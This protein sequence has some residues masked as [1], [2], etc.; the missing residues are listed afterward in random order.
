MPSDLLICSPDQV[1]RRAVAGTTNTAVGENALRLLT[2]FLILLSDKFSGDPSAE[3][4]VALADRADAEMSPIIPDQRLQGL[5]LVGSIV[6]HEQLDI[7]ISLESAFVLLSHLAA[8]LMRELGLS[9]H[10][11]TLRQRVEDLLEHRRA[12]LNS[13]LQNMARHE[14]SDLPRSAAG[15]MIFW[16]AQRNDN[17]FKK[18]RKEMRSNPAESERLFE[19]AYCS[20]RELVRLRFKQ[21]H[22]Y[23]EVKTF[24]AGIEKPVWNNITLSSIEA[25]LLVRSALGESGL[26][27]SI[28]DED[29]VAIAAQMFVHLA[30]QLDL[31][32]KMIL[33]TIRTVERERFSLG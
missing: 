25:E 12:E 29:I 19:I 17:E 15:R 28:S 30:E 10:D 11:A 21:K 9:E 2:T 6:R 18:S 31:P 5:A 32:N 27:D 3:S 23:E 1:A 8:Q 14:K 24:I 20:F 7:S 26:I 4:L 22:G 33:E 13:V 16:L